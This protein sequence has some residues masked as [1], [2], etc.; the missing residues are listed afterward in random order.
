MRSGV[1]IDCNYVI[2]V[3]KLMKKAYL[4]KPRLRKPTKKLYDI[5]GSRIPLI[6]I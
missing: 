3:K 2:S 4:S 6:I 5:D 1:N